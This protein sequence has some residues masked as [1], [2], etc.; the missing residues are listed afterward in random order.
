M[1]E[2]NKHVGRQTIHVDRF[3]KETDWDAIWGTIAI[4]VIGVVILAAVAS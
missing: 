4:F 1:F 2:K 3:K